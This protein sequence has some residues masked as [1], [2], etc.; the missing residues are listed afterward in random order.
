L[1]GLGVVVC[2][3]RHRQQGHGLHQAA[4]EQPPHVV[5]ACQIPGEGGQVVAPV[6]PIHEEAVRYMVIQALHLWVVD[7]EITTH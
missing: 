7:I 5:V 3:E 6:F 2:H 4:I 1:Q